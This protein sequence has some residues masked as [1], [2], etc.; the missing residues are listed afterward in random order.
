MPVW[1]HPPFPHH[2]LSSHPSPTPASAPGPSSPMPHCLH[3][4]LGIA[5]VLGSNC[6]YAFKM[7]YVAQK[8][9]PLDAIV[10]KMLDGCTPCRVHGDALWEHC[11]MFSSVCWPPPLWILGSGPTSPPWQWGCCEAVKC[12]FP[13]LSYDHV[14]LLGQT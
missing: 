8:N 4:A 5:A 6:R 11:G 10:P 3:I 14:H 7:G 13:L 1:M 2:P 12:L 9:P